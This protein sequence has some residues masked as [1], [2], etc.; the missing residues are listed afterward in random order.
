MGIYLISILK[1]PDW[2]FLSL[3][4]GEPLIHWYFVLKCHI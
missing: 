2:V 1:K 4:L 3:L